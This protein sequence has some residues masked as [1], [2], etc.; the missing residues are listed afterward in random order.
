MP[1]RCE[2][3]GSSSG[4]LLQD[5]GA[6]TVPGALRSWPYAWVAEASC[7]ATVGLKPPLCGWHSAAV[8]LKPPLRGWRMA[9]SL[10]AA[11]LGLGE[12]QAIRLAVAGVVGDVGGRR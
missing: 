10:L 2:N 8:G 6:P 12:G 11:T 4:S 7:R 9:T 3:V 1:M 5:R